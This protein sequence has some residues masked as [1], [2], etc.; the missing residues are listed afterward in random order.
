[1]VVGC[2]QHLRKQIKDRFNG[3]FA[4]FQPL[5]DR[6]SSDKAVVG[7]GKAAIFPVGSRGQQDDTLGS[8]GSDAQSLEVGIIADDG[9]WMKSEQSGLFLLQDLAF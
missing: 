6:W 9:I 2:S 3:C 8:P 7:L 5:G 4:A 1:M